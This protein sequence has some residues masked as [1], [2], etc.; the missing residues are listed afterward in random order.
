MIFSHFKNLFWAVAISCGVG[1][2]AKAVDNPSAADSPRVLV[3]NEGGGQHGP[4]TLRAMQWLD[5]VA[6]VK[7]FEI[8][9]MRDASRIDSTLLADIDLVV[10]LD[11]PPY[12][13]P[14]A[15]V[16]A[17]EKYVDRGLGAWIGFH[18]ATLLG[19]FDGYGL[20]KWFSDF[21]GSITFENYIAPL[22]D[23]DV[24]VENGQHPVMGGVAGRF[25]VADDEWYTY[26]RSPRPNVDVLAS[27]DESTYTPASD[28]VMGDHPV[29]WTNPSKPAKNVYF[30]MGHSPKL[31]DNRDFTLMFE[32][33]IDWTLAK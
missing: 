30:Q 6:A 21:M 3:L 32:N 28:I 7:N 17:F 12:T 4:F 26:D 13:W 29:V 16:D 19:E 9:E 18:H 1:F 2:G 5:S 10:Q 27:V 31:L 25:V 20:W 22:A 23:A 14:D 15:A 11:Y 8:I 24:V 33:A